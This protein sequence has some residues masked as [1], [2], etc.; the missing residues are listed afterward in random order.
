MKYVLKQWVFWVT[1][2][3]FVASAMY[4]GMAFRTGYVVYFLLAALWFYCGTLMWRRIK[5]EKIYYI[6]V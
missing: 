6:R 1:L 5:W 2:I 4:L 3:D